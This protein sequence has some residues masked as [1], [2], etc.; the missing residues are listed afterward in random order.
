MTGGG[1]VEGV[2][3]A[4]EYEAA[5][6][7]RPARR[8]TRASV[9]TGRPPQTLTAVVTITEE[10]EAGA[11]EATLNARQTTPTTPSPPTVT[12]TSPDPRLTPGEGAT[13]TLPPPRKSLT[14]RAPLRTSAP[15]A[16]PLRL[17]REVKGVSPHPL[18]AVTQTLKPKP[19]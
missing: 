15:L 12:S 18:A 8:Q 13:R 16:D 9:T 19:S 10:G 1:I 11:G 2:D 7:Q 17:P 4:T 3:A 14:L 6:A 5:Q